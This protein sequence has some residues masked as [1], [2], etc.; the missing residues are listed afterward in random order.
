MKK[1]ISLFMAFVMLF[2]V[3]SS[4]NLSAYAGSGTCGD[5]VSWSYDSTTNTLTI[6]G[7]GA[8]DDY[9]FS[10]EKIPWHGYR[11]NILTVKIEYGVTTIGRLAFDKCRNLT[12]ITI[13]NS[14]T[15][16]GEN[17]FGWC[18]SLTSIT[19]PNSVTTIGESAF[20]VCTR[21]TSVT[22]PN[23]VTTIGEGPFA[24]CDSLISI[25]VASGNL[26]YSSKDGVLFDKNKS[27]LIQYPVG[28]QRI[29]YAIPNSVKT[30]GDWAFAYCRSLTSVTIPDSVT[31]IGDWAFYFVDSLKDVYYSGSEEQWKKISI[32]EYNEPLTNATI[33]YNSP[34]PD[35]SETPE[36]PG[37]P[38]LKPQSFKVVDKTYK[39]KY[40]FYYTDDYFK[41]S[42]TK[43]NQSLATMSLCLALS[44][45]QDEDKEIY[46]ENVKNLFGKCG[47]VIDGADNT[48]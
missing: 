18:T 25:D 11:E 48:F 30:I 43:Y 26:N 22:I 41:K 5:N 33:H 37:S 16:I 2:S 46:H 28:N 44:T 4:V 19:I 40:G 9:V 20:Y 45:Y 6:Y 13:P 7:K 32:D 23:S 31:T 1:I 21:L 17:A 3:I 24:D 15:T 47:F 29:E 34:L 35:Q 42:A 10:N 8:M 36:N 38:K 12:S 14:V 39:D 27:K